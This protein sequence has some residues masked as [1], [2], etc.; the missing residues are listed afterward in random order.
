MELFVLG[1]N[2]DT[3]KGV[4]SGIECNVI[5]YLGTSS[6]LV[7]KIVKMEAPLGDNDE[8]EV[9]NIKL[10]IFDFTETDPFSE[11]NY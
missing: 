3:I 6:Q 4:D 11:G 1:T 10:D 2:N 5:N 8:L 7:L 9:E